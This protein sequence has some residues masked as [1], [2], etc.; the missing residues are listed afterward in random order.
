[1]SIACLP[2]QGQEWEKVVTFTPSQTLHSIKFASDNVGYTVSTLYNGSTYNIHKTEDGGETWIDQ[3][4]GYTSTRFKD[5]HVFSEDT[6]MMCGN[7]GLVIRTFDGGET[8]TSD[9]VPENGEH[10]SG[11]SFVGETGYISGNSG[12]IYKTTDLGETWVQVTPPASIAIDRIYFLTENYGFIYGLNFIYY[13]EDGGETWT[14]PQSFPGATTNWWLREMVFTSETTGYVCGDI[15]QVYKT[16]DGGKNWIFLDNTGTT[17]SLKSMAA[18]SE[19]RLYAC[20]YDGTVIRSSDGGIQWEPMTAA[21]S[22]HFNSIDFTPGGT[23]F[24]CTH[25]GEVLRYLDPY[26]AVEEIGIENEITVYPNPAVDQVNFSNHGNEAISRLY[27]EVKL[28][29]AEGAFLGLFP[30]DKPLNVSELSKGMYI[31]KFTEKNGKTE[32]KMFLKR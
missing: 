11:I 4:S 19:N 31:L 23:G 18:L 3:S 21:S 8:W 2:A 14:E 26:L 15:G 22:V 24:I 9:T 30:T 12:V 5:M 28:Y 13:T 17:V 7:F 1:M 6:V 29:N 32:S 25:T 16:T 10:L 20:G 27:P